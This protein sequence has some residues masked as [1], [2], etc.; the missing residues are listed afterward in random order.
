[1]K[2]MLVGIFVFGSIWGLL[3]CS[4]G[5]WLHSYDLTSLMVVVAIFLMAFTRRIFMQPGMQAGMALIAATLRYFNPIGGACLLCAS[6]AI[7]AQGLVFEALWKIPWLKY[8]NITMKVSM[9]IITF[10]S[11]AS[12]SYLVTQTL[13]PVLTATFYF[14]DLYGVMPKIF[15]H[16]LIA[17]L[18]G[19]FMLPITYLDIRLH[20]KEALYYPV[21]ITIVTICWVAVIGGV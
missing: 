9:G 19:S 12:I 11:I 3:E 17:G 4:L 2:K 14:T 13:T 21:S 16:A 15:A 10:F 18:A 6:I 1:M 8:Q 20:I 5:D 7:L